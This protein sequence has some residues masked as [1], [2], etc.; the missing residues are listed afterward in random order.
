M[1]ENKI[2]ERNCSFSESNIKENEK[3]YRFPFHGKSKYLI[4]KL[5][6]IGYDNETLNK[7]L[8][9]KDN[10]N[11]K[12]EDFD[13]MDSPKKRGSKMYLAKLS[14][15]A[16]KELNSRNENINSFSLPEPPSLLNEILNDY[17]KKVL[18]IDITINMIFPNKPVLYSYK[19]SKRQLSPDKRNAK[20]RRNTNTNFYTMR[21]DIGQIKNVNDEI[22]EK[23]DRKKY[24]M[25]FSSN[26]QIDKNNKKSINGFCYINYCKYKEKKVMNDFAYTFYVPIGICFIS[27]F[28]FY[29]SY[30]KLAEQIFC[31][32]NSKKIEVPIEIMLYNLINTALSPINGDIDL[33]IE[34]VSFLNNILNPA[35]NSVNK[36]REIE[37]SINSII[38]ENENK[39]NDQKE[40]R[41]FSLS[42]LTSNIND[43]DNKDDNNKKGDEKKEEE[44]KVEEKKEEENAPNSSKLLV[45]V[46]K[47][48]EKKLDLRSSLKKT[49]VIKDEDLDKII[50]T[51]SLGGQ[52][53]LQQNLFEP[54]KFPYLQGYP[55]CHYNLPKILF[56]NISISKLIFIFINTFLEKDILIFSENIELLSLIIN[57]LHSL[58]YPLN[59]NTYYVINASVSYNNYINGNL[60]YIS[61]AF[62]S[63]I[64]INSSFKLNYLNENKNKYKEHIIY[65]LDSKEIYIQNK[66]DSTFFQYI[67]KILKVKDDKEYKGSLLSYEI[68]R[69]YDSLNVTREKYTNLLLTKNQ[70]ENN[71]FYRKDFNLE[72][73]EAFY[74]FIV[75]ILV[76]YYRQLIYQMDYDNA[77]QNNNNDN[78]DQIR[79]EFN[80]NYESESNIKYKNTEEE[81]YFFDDFK[82]TFKYDI[83]F[84]NYINNH[85]SLDLY[86]ISYIFLEEY[87]SILSRAINPNMNNNYVLNFF[88]IFENLYNKKQ[89]QKTN[90]DFNTFLSEYFKKY[91]SF[92]ERD[93]IDFNK[94][95]KQII[96]LTEKKTLNYQWYELDNRLLLNYILLTKSLN[97]DE[98]ERMFNLNSILNENIPK[99]I[100]ISDIEDEIEKE[101]F[102]NNNY[103]NNGLL[104]NDDDICCMNII[105]LISLTLKYIDM[106]NYMVI[107]IGNL[108]KDFFLFRKYYHMLMDMIYRVILI[109][110]NENKSHNVERINNLLSFYYPCINSF[111]EKNIIPNEK[112]VQIISNMNQIDQDIRN[113]KIINSENIDDDLKEENNPIDK[114]NYIIFVYHNFSYYGILKEK[115][116]IEYINREDKSDKNNWKNRLGFI[117]GLR[118]EEKKILIVPKIKYISKYKNKENVE[119]NLSVESEVFSQR[120]LKFILNEE[121]QKYINN[122]LDDKVLDK[123]NI[124]NCLLNIIIYIRNS[125]KYEEKYELEE[126]FKTILYHHMSSLVK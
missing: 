31:L 23:M 9:K 110:L 1:I 74:R 33:C 112:I 126:A 38:E 12:I 68:K 10:N 17:N 13:D 90:I 77:N 98:Y 100:K 42:D 88:T 103:Y 41:P 55:L 78:N 27:E 69:L 75:N 26:P 104:I 116:I 109:K 5:Y 114:N 47:K 67:K 117:I 8:I 40:I 22:K 45:H 4:D 121:Y 59:D 34:P 119:Y 20:S 125:K 92:F 62:N 97:T 72:I 3:I 84:N 85:E 65:D 32:F 113:Q 107:I 39:N 60:N 19:E 76:Y 21:S 108:F 79:I 25:V 56:N 30:Y 48:F 7:Y 46:E 63:I 29:N 115:N 15:T 66:N 52:R 28:P 53:H 106:E 95:G 122:N 6:I 118:N 50:K 111:R 80:K 49:I 81:K 94:D 58:N 16:S 35:S 24:C 43:N 83:F 36:K 54:I 51:K 11:F 57:S 89:S 124:L 64:G 105:I 44:K 71:I 70:N 87:I 18:D 61:T 37:N 101:I 86:N 120:K 99:R 2:K 14:Q 123:R 91:K 73:Q 96:R 102:E 82:N 93:I